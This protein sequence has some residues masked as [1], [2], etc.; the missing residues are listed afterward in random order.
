MKVNTRR[1]LNIYEAFEVRHEIR[2]CD[3]SF[4][5]HRWNRKKNFADQ[6]YK[7][8][9]RSK[10]CPH[11]EAVPT[12][13]KRIEI[14]LRDNFFKR[15]VIFFDI[16][17]KKKPSERSLYTHIVPISSDCVIGWNIEC[18]LIKRS[19]FED[20]RILNRYFQ[21]NRNLLRPLLFICEAILIRSAMLHFESNLTMKTIDVVNCFPSKWNLT[22]M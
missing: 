7:G 1:P 15:N 10:L 12:F 16:D 20:F 14:F 19:T 13:Y 5:T 17:I 8:M 2:I 4:Q 3:W 18:F 22:S 9:F 11:F 6:L 21:Y